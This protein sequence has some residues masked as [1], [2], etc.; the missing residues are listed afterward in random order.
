MYFSFW[1]QPQALRNLRR[2]EGLMD[3][4]AKELAEGVGNWCASPADV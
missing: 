3:A 2:H 1:H 4:V